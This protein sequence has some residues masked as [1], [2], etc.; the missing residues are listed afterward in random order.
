MPASLCQQCSAQVSRPEQRRNNRVCAAKPAL[1]YDR[2]N[3]QVQ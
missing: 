1:Q 3:A 2:P